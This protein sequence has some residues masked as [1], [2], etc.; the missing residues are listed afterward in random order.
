[1]LLLLERNGLHNRAIH[2]L[3]SRTKR[4]SVDDAYEQLSTI[5]GGQVLT[6]ETNDISELASFVSFSAMQNRNTIFRREGNLLGTA[7][8][9]FPVDTFT[10]EVFISIDT[11]QSVTIS[12]VNPQG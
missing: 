3:N 2:K 5:S 8:F 1:M 7:Q 9:E 11:E 12:I 6:V 4:Q 10:S